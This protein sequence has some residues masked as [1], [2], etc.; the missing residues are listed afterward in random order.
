MS[1]AI[2]TYLLVQKENSSSDLSIRILV[3]DIEISW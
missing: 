1:V 2:S 3:Q